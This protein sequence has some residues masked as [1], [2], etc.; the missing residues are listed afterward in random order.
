MMAVTPV[1]TI[2]GLYTRVSTRNQAD[3]EYSSLETQRE[4]LEAYCK[5]Q[6]QY[7]IYRVYEDAGFSADTM[8]RPALKEL[9]QDIRAGRITCVLAYKIDR[10][11]RSVKDFHVLMD[12]FDRHGAKFVSITQSLDTHH[13]MGRLLRNILLD[14]AQFEREMTADRTRDKMQQR[15]TKGLWNGGNVPFGYRN[16]DKRLVKHPEEAACVQFMF[17]HFAQDPSLT[18][19]RAELQRRGWFPRT[20]KPWGKMT[21][22]YIL[23]N[24]IYCGRI[25]FN[26]QLFPGEHEALIEEGLYH[27]VQS[28][29]REHS[30]AETKIQRTFLLK[31]LLRCS[32]CQSVMTPHYTQKRR[33]DQSINRIA[34]YRCTK[35]MQHNNAVCT[36]K[37]LNADTVERQVIEYLSTLS[38]QAEW[39]KVT[40]EELNR[41]QKEQVRPLEQEAIRL[42]ASLNRLEREIDRLV[43]G[44]GQGTVSV[45]RLEDE[46]RRQQQEQH[47]LETQ[48]QAVQRQI[49]EHTAR[50]YDSE[51]VLR[52]LKNFQKIFAALLPKEKMEVLRCLVRDIVVHPDKLIFNI[53]ELAEVGTS[54][55]ERKGWLPSD[56]LSEHWRCKVRI[57]SD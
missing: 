36:I 7:V 26:D 2:C 18:R 53:F 5:S 8:N 55:Q 49:E 47:S 16:E 39:V 10:L 38:Q 43:R 17:Q 12:L 32:V 52:N 35:T 19:L 41:D 3:T 15:A 21:L 29:P 28:L 25:Q 37:A 46:M 4:K 20:G 42:R 50:E 6:D 11:T 23:T 30:R 24:P 56:T 51:I 34:Y 14:F 40:V 54:S 48:Y 31:G 33:K 44:V 9:L 22:D 57:A 13:P 27:K 45:Q 1:P